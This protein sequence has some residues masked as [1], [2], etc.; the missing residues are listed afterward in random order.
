MHSTGFAEDS[1]FRGHDILD[2]VHVDWGTFSLVAALK[3]MLRTALADRLN[4]KF[5]LLSESGIP[6]YPPEVGPAPNLNPSQGCGFLAWGEVLTQ[7]S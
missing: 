6:I 7:H 2:R 5:I 1:I 4:Q 3:N